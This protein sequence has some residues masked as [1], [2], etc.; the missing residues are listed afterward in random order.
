MKLI[1]V[2]KA[3]YRK[4]FNIV[5]TV[6]ITVL[7]IGSLGIAQGLIYLFPIDQGSHFHW[8]LRA[9]IVT[10]IAILIT[11]NYHKHQPFLAEVYY[12]LQLKKSLSLVS[13]KLHKL[14]KAAE[15]GHKNAMLAL[16]FSYKGSRQLWELA[17]NTITMNQLNGHQKKLDEVMV[18]F[19]VLVDVAD[20]T[21]DISNEF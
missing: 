19:D 7:V 13:R 8:N 15:N 2:D 17:D 21:P 5:I 3:R 9:V 16:Q 1:G 14:E 6:I 20:Y 12:V 4:H 18:K 11:L 10:V